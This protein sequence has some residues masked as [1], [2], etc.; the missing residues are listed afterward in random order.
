MRTYVCAYVTSSPREKGLNLT[1]PHFL[2]FERVKAPFK[3]ASTLMNRD[4][5]HCTHYIV[6]KC[7]FLRRV[8]AVCKVCINMGSRE[9]NLHACPFFSLQQRRSKA[10]KFF[11]VI[12]SFMRSSTRGAHENIIF[13]GAELRVP[14]L[15]RGK[16]GEGA[17]CEIY[18]DVLNHH[19]DLHGEVRGGKCLTL[20][21]CTQGT[22]FSLR[23]LKCAKIVHFGQKK[24]ANVNAPS[25]FGTTCKLYPYVFFSWWSQPR[26]RRGLK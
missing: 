25:Q 20:G 4:K 22:F 16:Q 12:G 26:S 11:A 1:C 2:W 18:R 14:L 19:A 21:A 3:G 15:G 6:C 10:C 7:S 17:A 24:I 5:I 8:A 13:D 9:Q 23:H